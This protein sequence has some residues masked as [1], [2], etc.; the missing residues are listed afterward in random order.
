MRADPFNHSIY[1]HTI[2]NFKELGHCRFKDSKISYFNE[3]INVKLCLEV[4]S[5]LL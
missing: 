2:R 3:E 5:K 4:N 1:D